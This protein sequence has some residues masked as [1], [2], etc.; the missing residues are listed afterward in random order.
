MTR[1]NFNR[2]RDDAGRVRDCTLAV[3][4]LALGSGLGLTGCSQP[5]GEAQP[6]APVAAD[7]V[8]S[9]MVR[10]IER[11]P[12]ALIV[13]GLAAPQGRVVLHSDG[14]TAYATGA[15]AQGRFDLRILPPAVDTLFVVEARNGQDASPA[16]YQLLVSQDPKG[17]LALLASGAPS[18]RLDAAGPLDVI[19]S[20]GEAALASGRATPGAMVPVVVNGGAPIQARTG[21]NGRWS[22]SLDLTA[23][24]SPATV[25][26]AGRAYDYPGAASVAAPGL[27]TTSSPSGWRMAWSTRQGIGQ[28]SWFPRP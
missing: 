28:S 2:R 13:K 19:D 16:P 9:P 15:D 5:V 23:Q 17:P 20:D 1:R 21:R 26:V 6:T 22:V 12:S 3:A 11:T 14:Q 24:A 7:W 27:L 4:V 18:V 25:T 8:M 10:S